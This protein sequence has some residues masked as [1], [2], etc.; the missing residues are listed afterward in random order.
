LV[1]LEPTVL[2]GLI[3]SD[4]GDWEGQPIDRIAS[5]SPDLYEAFVAADA[6]FA[7]P[8]GGEPDKGAEQDLSRSAGDH[9]SGQG[10]R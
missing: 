3:E 5:S 4:R 2:A 1:G 6:G 8:G 10:R 9:E 7:F